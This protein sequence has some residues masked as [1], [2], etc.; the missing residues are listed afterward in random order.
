MS[1][2]RWVPVGVTT[3]TVDDETW[4]FAGN[5]VGLIIGAGEEMRVLNFVLPNGL[6]VCR[7]TDQPGA[8]PADVREAIGYIVDTILVDRQSD[9]GRALMMVRA[10][11]QQAGG[12]NDA[13]T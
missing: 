6:A 10:W 11:L 7:L 1:S 3:H 5:D 12:G 8:V 9:L 2:K 4:A 13:N